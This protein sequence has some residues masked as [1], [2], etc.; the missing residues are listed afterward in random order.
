MNLVEKWK[1][2][3]GIENQNDKLASS[4]ELS[5][6]DQC[7]SHFDHDPNPIEIESIFLAAIIARVIT[8]DG[9]VEN[10][11]RDFLK[12]ELAKFY[13]DEKN[14]H[15]NKIAELAVKWSKE[16]SQ[17]ENQVIG[18]Y[19]RKNYS[20]EKNFH[21]LKL[22]VRCSAVDEQITN[23]E[24]EELRLIAH[25]LDLSPQHFLAARAEYKDY[26]LSLKK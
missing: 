26:L 21:L 3:L 7:I 5:L 19:F 18:N 2:W 9:V 15:A 22:L 6:I 8:C 10:A 1:I 13:H 11:E 4:Y 14:D 12:L 24:S 17:L 20:P 23:M 25:S 16:F